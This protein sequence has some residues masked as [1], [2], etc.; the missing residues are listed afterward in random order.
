VSV[1]TF[2]GSILTVRVSSAAPDADPPVWVDISDFV[3]LR[4]G[5][6]E[7]ASG[8]QTVL[9]GD[10]PA[11]AMFALNNDDHRFT[12]G[13]PL[14]PYFP[15]WKEARRISIQERVGGVTFDLFDGNIQVPGVEAVTDPV[16]GQG[17]ELTVGISAMDRLARL[18]TARPFPS[19]VGAQ[20]L[21]SAAAPALRAYFPLSEA[22]GPFYRP[23]VGTVDPLEEAPIVVADPTAVA[24]ADGFAAAS[25]GPIAANDVRVVSFAPQMKLSG[26][27]YSPIAYTQ[28]VTN[29]GAGTVAANSVISMAVWVSPDPASLDAQWRVA[30]LGFSNGLS[31]G[32][33][34]L[35]R[36]DSTESPGG[37][38]KAFFADDFSAVWSASAYGVHAGA[39]PTLLAIRADLLANTMSLFVDGTEYPA[40]VTGTMVTSGLLS[41]LNVGY[42]FTGAMGDL[43][44][45]VGTQA[46]NYDL[47]AHR[48]QLAVGFYALDQQ[49]TGQR[50]HTILDYAGVPASLRDI[51]PGVAVM[52][53]VSLAGKTP[54]TALEEARRTE[55]G[56]LFM[57]GNGRVQFRDRT[58]LYNV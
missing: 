34:R 21:S 58:R 32:F 25:G 18:Q 28:L 3:T 57:S 40:T 56:R 46:V 12:P 4:S 7:I 24:S 2:W 36:T 55:Q 54:G 22:V 29:F 1:T 52:S 23:V 44:I 43:Q 39:K 35:R 37:V 8:R 41:A 31:G 26:A 49:Y 10:D 38:W 13:N 14:S 17:T 15:W 48:A 20:I 45:Y 6:L 11:Q 5:D 53:P 47:A 42:A 19:T 33:L 30:E 27:T 16:D 51:D 50:I 9:V